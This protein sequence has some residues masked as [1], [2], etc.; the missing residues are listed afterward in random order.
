[1]K[2]AKKRENTKARTGKMKYK[3][4]KSYSY[5]YSNGYNKNIDLL[6]DSINIQEH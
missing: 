1:M 4:W 5:N 3:I 6:K 2:A